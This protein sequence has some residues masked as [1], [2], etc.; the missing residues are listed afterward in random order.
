[1]SGFNLQAGD[2]ALYLGGELDFDNAAEA[3]ASVITHIESQ[4]DLTIDLAGVSKSNSAGLALMIEWL[5]RASKAGHAIQYRNVPEGLMELARVSQVDEL[6][7][8]GN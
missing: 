6:I 3:L 1:M 5:A 8:A 4:G 2:D 7:A